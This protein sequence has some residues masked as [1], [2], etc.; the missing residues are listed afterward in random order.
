M[1]T[2]IE[3]RK[4]IIG[5][6]SLLGAAA[7]LPGRRATGAGLPRTPAQTEGPFYPLV[8]PKAIDNDLI[9]VPGRRG[10]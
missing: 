7:W 4:W 3:R 1:A 5:A 6:A 8:R 2:R 10:G 9:H